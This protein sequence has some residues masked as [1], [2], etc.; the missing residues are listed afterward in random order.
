LFSWSKLLV[1]IKVGYQETISCKHLHSAFCACHSRSAYGCSL[2]AALAKSEMFARSSGGFLGGFA[3]SACLHWRLHSWHFMRFLFLAAVLLPPFAGKATSSRD[4]LPHGCF[5]LSTLFTNVTRMWWSC[6]SFA[7][8]IH[9]ETGTE[10]SKIL[11]LHADT[12]LKLTVLGKV[13]ETCFR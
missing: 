12:S 6:W 11:F 5:S 8:G 3:W 9:V 10:C 4:N 2:A 13:R 1:M 7:V